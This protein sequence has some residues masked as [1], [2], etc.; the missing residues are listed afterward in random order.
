M[1]F[2]ESNRKKESNI[3]SN[4][5]NQAQEQLQLEKT[6]NEQ[7]QKINSLENSLAEVTKKNAEAQKAIEKLCAEISY[8]K[9]K[10]KMND[11]RASLNMKFFEEL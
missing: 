11:S 6:I 10:E 2:R 5:L 4:N 3:A 8:Q 9:N 1:K 7:K